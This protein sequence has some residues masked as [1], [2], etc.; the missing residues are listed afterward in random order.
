MPHKKVP[1]YY[2]YPFQR[3]WYNDAY[4]TPDGPQILVIGGEAPAIPYDVLYD[5]FP[6]VQHAMA[7]KAGLWTLE[8]RF[9]GESQPF[10]WGFDT[11][12]QLFTPF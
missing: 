1:F 4:A 6:H 9:Y 8:H 12:P 11:M 2:Q 10:K 7:L 5:Q 3:Y